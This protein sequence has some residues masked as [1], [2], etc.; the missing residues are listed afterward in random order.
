VTE[1]TPDFEA[2]GLLEGLEGTARGAR[3]RLLE[4]L[5]AAGVGMEELKQ[6]VEQDR[7]VILPAERALGGGGGLSAAEICERAGLPLEFF[8]A[9]RRAHGLAADPHQRAYGEEDLEAAAIM[10]RFYELGLDRDGMLEVARVLGRGLSQAADAL[11]NLFG[12]SFIKAGVTEEELGT[13]NA[14]AAREWL[15][16]LTPLL[17]YLLKQHMRERLRHQAVSQSMLEAGELPGA[18]NVAVS[19][20]DM[21]A[22]T[23]LG[24]RLPSEEVAGIAGRLDVLASDCAGPPVRLVKTIGD[25]AMFVAPEA[26][27]LLRTTMDLIAAARG[28]DGFPQLRAGAAFGPALNRSGDWYGRSVNLA[29]RI[30]DHADPETVVGTRELC[31]AAGPVCRWES[32]GPQQLKGIDEPVELFRAEATG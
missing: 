6:A 7:L 16:Q 10:A 32:L 8:L 23:P 30:A 25:A 27:A 14:E 19:F 12:Q 9:V 22:F 2:E 28:M 4:R 5:H 11:G 29:S 20:V 26:G 17:E 24:E 3:S 1:P 15:P 21:V 18:R 31:D 13:R